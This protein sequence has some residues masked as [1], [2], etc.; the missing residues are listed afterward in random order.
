MSLL[1]TD[2]PSASVFTSLLFTSSSKTQPGAKSAA[3]TPALRAT[4]RATSQSKPP[5]PYVPRPKQST[6]IHTSLRRLLTPSLP[7]SFFLVAVDPRAAVVAVAATAAIAAAVVIAP[8]LPSCP[9]PLLLSSSSS[10]SFKPSFHPL[11]TLP[12]G[13]TQEGISA[14]ALPK[15]GLAEEEGE[16]EQGDEE[17]KLE[18]EEEEA[19]GLGEG[20][21]VCAEIFAVVDGDKKEEEGEGGEGGRR[22]ASAKAALNAGSSSFQQ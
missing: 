2:A 13:E 7:A 3:D 9:C 14:T 10:S 17:K 16:D 15:R 19:E 18:E 4:L 22:N 12:S 1:F 11:F 21:R 8:V 5:P 20:G 6:P